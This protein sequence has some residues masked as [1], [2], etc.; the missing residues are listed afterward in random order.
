MT[1]DLVEYLKEK[2]KDCSC[3]FYVVGR[4]EIGF[5][6]IR[7]WEKSCPKHTEADPWTEWNTEQFRLINE[8]NAK[9]WERNEKRERTMSRFFKRG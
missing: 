9:E 3:S 1:E 7:T 6:R 8:G 2:L 4:P 5:F